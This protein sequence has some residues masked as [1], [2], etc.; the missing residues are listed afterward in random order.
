MTIYTRTGDSGTTALFG[1]KRVSK[2]DSRV[3]SYGSIDELN[4]A[5]GLLLSSLPDTMRQRKILHSIQQ[6]LFTCASC[7]AGNNINMDGI[8]ERIRDIEETIDAMDKSVPD[9][10]NF[11]LPGGSPA[12]ALAHVVR[13]ICRK[14]ERMVV[15]ENTR[16]RYDVVVAYLNRVS[17]LL[18][19]LAR[20]INKIDGAKEE[21]WRGNVK[22]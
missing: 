5:L 2:G 11:I 20:F 8:Q 9:L 13:T 17:D 10:H 12:G 3:E 7:I 19:V 6:D 16:G 14:T 4:S 1:G 22:M 18:F 21:L 15:K